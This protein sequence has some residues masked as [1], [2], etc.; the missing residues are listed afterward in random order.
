M[1]RTR[2]RL[3][4]ARREVQKKQAD[5]LHRRLKSKKSKRTFEYNRRK[6]SG[7]VFTTIPLARYG[8]PLNAKRTMA[9][10]SDLDTGSGSPTFQR[11]AAV[12]VQPRPLPNLPEGRIHSHAS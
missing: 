7:A 2:D 10:S 3:K 6:G 5:R 12:D 8:L 4:K 11:T 9:I 1:S